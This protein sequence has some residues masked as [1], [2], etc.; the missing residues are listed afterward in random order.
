VIQN[1]VGRTR[2]KHTEMINMCKILVGKL[3]INMYLGL[4]GRKILK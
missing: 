2:R 4:D 3:E 1:V